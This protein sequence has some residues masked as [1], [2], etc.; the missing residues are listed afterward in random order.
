MRS[1]A[2]TALLLLTM[3]AAVAAAAAAAARASPR[4]LRSLPPAAL[5]H[6]TAPRG[7]LAGLGGGGYSAA[8]KRIR[9]CHSGALRRTVPTMMPEGPEVRTLVDQLQPAVG[10]RLV[11]LRFLSGRY[12]RHGRPKGFDDFRRT[13]SRSGG[14]NGGT[15]DLI[16]EWNAKGKFIYLVLD[17]G[18]KKGAVA[19]DHEG[20][21]PPNDYLRSIWITLGMSGRFL[22][23]T[24]NS[25]EGNMYNYTSSDGSNDHVRWSLELSDP[26]TGRTRTIYYHDVRNFGTLRFSLSESELMSKLASLGPD[27]L[28]ENTT[29]EDFLSVMER[30]RPELNV[31]KFLMNQAKICGVGNYI[32]AE[33]LYRSSVDPFA[34]LGELSDGQRRDLFTELRETIRMSYAAQGMTRG[35][36]GSYRLPDG[37]RG[38][39]EFEL[40]CY[41]RE[42]CA[43]GRPV[44]KETDGPHG[45]TIWYVEDQLFVPRSERGEDGRRK[46]DGAPPVGTGA[47]AGGVWKEAAP[48]LPPSSPPDA[49][50]ASTATTGGP[51]GS[52]ADGLVDPG[53]RE[54]LGDVLKSDAFAELSEFVRSERESGTPVYPPEAEVFSALNACPPDRV[55]VV[56]VG[57]DPYHGPGQGHGMA[58]SVGP[59]VAVPPSLRNVLREAAADPALSGAYDAPPA[60]F[61]CLRC[62][63]D[64]G[65]LLLNS[66]LTVRAGEAN[67]HR[68]RG[69][70]ELTDRVIEAACERGGGGSAGERGGGVVFLLW[71]G[72]AHKKAA[73]V[74]GSRH[75][76]IRTSHPSPL[77][78]TKTASPFLGSGCFGRA[79]AALVEAGGEPIDWSVRP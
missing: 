21:I 48:V 50:A 7:R 15:S 43:E 65:V 64:Q 73:G 25:A 39:F 44:I 19:G 68:G 52:L 30:Q 22:S 56:I 13:M 28:D 2:G 14:G 51:A 47:R 42:E 16:A 53:W 11:D 70:E 35:S 67:S 6:L 45:R 5:A 34:C 29:L 36:G 62:W 57:Q 79:N 75:T 41:G 77:G 76:V 17:E 61:G 66:V 18:Q 26:E 20:A 3:T 37:E 9:T 54:A 59:G 49:T 24:A 46:P 4:L 33:G 58:F 74:D 32:L 60:G 69:W 27:M 40:Q 71:G 23:D 31:C 12:V 38:G 8:L 1:V 78:A 72:P 10:M 63:A 55:R